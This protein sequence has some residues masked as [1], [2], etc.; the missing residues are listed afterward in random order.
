M[1]AKFTHVQSGSPKN[2]RPKSVLCWTVYLGFDPTGNRI[3]RYERPCLPRSSGSIERSSPGATVT[4]YPFAY[5]DE[6]RQAERSAWE[7]SRGL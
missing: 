4:R 3:D 7:A 1:V 5:L 2:R 6:F